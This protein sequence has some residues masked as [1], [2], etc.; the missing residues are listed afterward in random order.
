MTKPVQKPV[1]PDMSRKHVQFVHKL[2]QINRKLPVYNKSSVH[3]NV[4]KGLDW[5]SISI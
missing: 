3:K 2:R 1:Q 5:T 4:Q